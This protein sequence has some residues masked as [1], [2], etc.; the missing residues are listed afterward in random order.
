MTADGPRAIDWGSAVRAPAA[1]D[2][3]SSHVQLSEL[4]PE[5]ADNP[6][7]PRAVNAAVQA[8]YARLTGTPEATL[9]AAAKPYLPIVRLLLFAGVAPALRERLIQRVEAALLAKD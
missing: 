5:V 1:L 8:A 9:A 2:L 7:R 6:Q 4:A 3:A